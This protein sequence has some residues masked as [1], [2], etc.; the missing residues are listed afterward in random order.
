MSQQPQS[1]RD[2]VKVQGEQQSLQSQQEAAMRAASSQL[3]EKIQNP[4]FLSELQDAKVDSDKHDWVSAELGPVFAGA[5]VLGHR[6]ENQHPHRR[7]WLNKNKAER[8]V[9]ESSP[10]R[11]LREH[12]SMLAI[13][14]RKRPEHVQHNDIKEPMDSEDRRVT[15]DAMEAATDYE[16][17]AAGGQGREAVSTATTE[18]RQVTN[19]EQESESG[20]MKNKLKSFYGG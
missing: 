9:A 12:T 17:M 14:Q 1:Y 16:S 6:D 10:G 15:R 7:Q 3:Q 5:K 11:L 18:A 20:G 4:D 19:Q 8:L 13:S 2:Q